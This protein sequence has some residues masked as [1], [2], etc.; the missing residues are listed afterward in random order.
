[1]GNRWLGEIFS[2][3]WLGVGSSQAS[4]YQVESRPDQLFLPFAKIECA[5]SNILVQEQK[6]TRFHT[7]SD[8]LANPVQG[9]HVMQRTVE[10]NRIVAGRRQLKNVAIANQ[11]FDIGI[12]VGLCLLP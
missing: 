2:D 5:R 4:R 8:L 9:F 11:V 12:A 7:A 3:A 1:I 10:P 6:S